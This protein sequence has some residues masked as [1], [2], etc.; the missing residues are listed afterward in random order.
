MTRDVD[1]TVNFY[2]SKDEVVANGDGDWHP[3]TE[4]PRGTDP[5]GGVGAVE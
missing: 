3:I 5:I 1:N 4:V 2:S